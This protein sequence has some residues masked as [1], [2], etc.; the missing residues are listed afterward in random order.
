M[1]MAMEMLTWRL[2]G[3]KIFIGPDQSQV[4]T[5]FTGRNF[6]EIS[7]SAVEFSRNRIGCRTSWL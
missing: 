2:L 5:S 3:A 4:S 1:L 7:S 6:Q